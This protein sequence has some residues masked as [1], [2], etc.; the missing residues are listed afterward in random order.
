MTVQVEMEGS[1]EFVRMKKLPTTKR[2]GIK[3]DLKI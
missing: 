1:E 3:G 2:K